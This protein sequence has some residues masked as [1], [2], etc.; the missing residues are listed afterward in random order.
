M[1]LR[2]LKRRSMYRSCL[3]FLA[4]ALSSASAMFEDP[5]KP[6]LSAE[7]V[8]GGTDVR[9]HFPVPEEHYLYEDDFSFTVLEG[10]WDVLEAPEA[11]IRDDP[12]TGEPVKVYPED[13]LLRLRIDQP[14][15]NVRLRLDYMG[16]N[17]ELCFMPQSRLF[18]FDAQGEG[19]EVRDAADVDEPAET[20]LGH[21][22]DGLHLT[23]RQAGF[24]SVSAFLDFI[25]QV[26]EGR[27]LERG[28][29]E[30]IADVYGL[31]IGVLAVLLGGLALNLT[32]C[33]LPMIPV[34]IAII[35]AGNQAGSRWRGLALGTVYGLG[36]AL[37][38]GLLG[39]FVVLTG[40][41]FGTLNASPWFNLSIALLF[42]FLSLAMFGVFN[43]DFSRW[44]SKLGNPTTSRGSY[45]TAFFFGSVAALLAGAC[46]AP[47]VISVLVLATE[48]YQR[49]APAALLLPFVL[50]VGMALPWPFAGAGLSFL[51]KPGKWME[52]V[53][54][55]FG[56]VIIVTAFYYGT[57]GFSLLRLQAT[58]D[59]DQVGADRFWETSPEVAVNRMRETGKP[60]FIDFWATW[61]KNCLAM[62]ATTFQDEEVREALEP[63]VRLKFQAENLRDP[64][65]RRVLDRLGIQG[66]PSYVVLSR[67]PME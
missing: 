23:G 60:L 35:G 21:W 39:V 44:Q 7:G 58:G 32:P 33:V 22:L 24:L 37:A 1:F 65:T 61:C 10:T 13:V 55:V 62:D 41:Q 3:L 16:C 19:I 15:E 14:L 57:L 56:V 51:P 47:V 59:A 20:V 50:G 34:N 8:S 40:A 18:V 63:Y 48:F 66:L 2:P 12:F 28:R 31:W 36:I 43:L 29:L 42:L 17:Q 6:S 5:F 26:E 46:V 64:E 54:I 45:A 67:E 52:R 4:I 11:V 25:S 49:G 27:G 30:K 38:Y 9:I 53:K